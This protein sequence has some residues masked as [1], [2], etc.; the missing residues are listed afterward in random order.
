MI[1][2]IKNR[3]LINILGNIIASFALMVT[4][5]NVNTACVYIAHQPKLPVSAKELRKF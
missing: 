4:T 5:L 2:N 3:K 1:K